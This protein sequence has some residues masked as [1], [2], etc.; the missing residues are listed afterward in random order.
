MKR[1]SS[2]RASVCLA[3]LVVLGASLVWGAETYWTGAVNGSW[4]TATLNWAVKGSGQACAWN[5]QNDT[6]IDTTLFAENSPMTLSNEKGKTLWINSFLANIEEGKTVTIDLF[7]NGTWSSGVVPFRKTGAGTLAY[8]VSKSARLIVIGA[9]TAE[10]E[11]G[12]LVVSAPNVKDALANVGSATDGRVASNKLTEYNIHKGAKFVIGARQMTGDINYGSGMRVRVQD[13][14]T[15]QIGPNA[16]GSP[17][18]HVTVDE[19]LLEGGEVLFEG[20]SEA[21]YGML[22]AGSLLKVTGDKP[23]VLSTG[24]DAT[25]EFVLGYGGNAV[26][27]LFQDHDYPVVDVADVTGDDGADLDLDMPIAHTAAPAGNMVSF[28]KKG[29]GTVRFTYE[30]NPNHHG[31]SGNVNILEGEVQ[32]YGINSF[33]QHKGNRVYVSTNATLTIAGVAATGQLNSLSKGRS[34]TSIHIDHGRYFLRPR[35]QNK[36]NMGDTGYCYIGKELTLENAVFDSYVKSYS[37]DNDKGLAA[38]IAGSLVHVKAVAGEPWCADLTPCDPSIPFQT[39]QLDSPGTEF[40]VE[41]TTG[42][43]GVDAA[44]GFRLID[45]C[46]YQGTPE[47][48]ALVKTG[49]GTL[50]VTNKF[51]AVSSVEVREGTLLV[52]NPA[53]TAYNDRV[54]NAPNGQSY[55]GNNLAEGGHVL[56]TT[57]GTLRI[58][59]TGQYCNGSFG[60]TGGHNVTRPLIVDGGL[61]DIAGNAGN[62]YSN[63]QM[64]GPV[65]LKNG[66]RLDY[67]DSKVNLGPFGVHGTLTVSGTEP[68]TLPPA[69]AGGYS[70]IFLFPDYQT[71]FDVE[72]VTGDLSADL[73]LHLCPGMPGNSQ[74]FDGTADYCGKGQPGDTW[75]YGWTKTGAGTM[76]LAY[77]DPYRYH[78]LPAIVSN[79][80]LVVN[81]NFVH[82]N[83]IHVEKTGKDQVHTCAGFEVR[84]GAFIG[85]CGSVASV[86][87]EP[88]AGFFAEY[89]QTGPLTSAA[90]IAL[91]AVGTVVV[92]APRE[93]DRAAMK[94]VLVATALQG[95]T[96]VENLKNWRVSVP[97]HEDEEKLFQLSV[98]GN[99][100]R[101][102]NGMGSAILIR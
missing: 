4:D 88:G 15:L 82:L 9:S 72:D 90:P 98:R 26:G 54:A 69:S 56:V 50:M 53:A 25:R 76:V 1:H 45:F 63:M 97:G 49:A 91:P 36:N 92:K 81:A 39:F 74:Y 55:L 85:G 47:L 67:T 34:T 24:G 80:T 23:Y 84:A 21:Q 83:T 43:E 61:V 79:G 22:G 40:R 77:C 94:G 31:V 95:F 38:L 87:L 100:L 65:V 73:T 48:S 6:I 28:T 27:N 18:S 30:G 102:G 62:G 99:T 44:L 57:N 29:A 2:G 17:I 51:N 101:V 37:A 86:T 13:G 66:G 96:G 7:L 33:H 64:F 46:M 32:F 14:A 71:Q 16:G 5:Q 8:K 78:T 52:K 41:D 58:D 42:D 10:I 35:I 20:P 59:T 12:T 93:L 75:R 3:S 11:E 68:V 60:Y 89:G 70:R 19:L